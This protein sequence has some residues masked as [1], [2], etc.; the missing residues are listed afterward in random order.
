MAYGSIICDLCTEILIY[1]S[2]WEIT[3]K[4]FFKTVHLTEGFSLMIIKTV[5]CPSYLWRCPFYREFHYSKSY[6]KTI[7]TCEKCPFYGGVRLTEV[8]VSRELTVLGLKVQ[9][10]VQCVALLMSPLF[11][12][13]ESLEE[14]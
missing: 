8:S 10:K 11:S 6:T 13:N 12:L 7:G 2:Y 3:S 1:D 4:D 9:K 14:T 5:R